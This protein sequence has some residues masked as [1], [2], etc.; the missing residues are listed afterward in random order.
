MQRARSQAS[1]AKARGLFGRR[2]GRRQAERGRARARRPR[3][4]TRT[5]PANASRQHVKPSPLSAPVPRWGTGPP[6][7]LPWGEWRE[8]KGERGGGG[9]RPKRVPSPLTQTNSRPPP[10]P[11]P[12][13]PLPKNSPCRPPSPPPPPPWPCA[14]PPPSRPPCGCGRPRTVRVR[15]GRAG[16]VW[17]VFGHQNS[18]DHSWPA[19]PPPAIPARAAPAPPTPT[20]PRPMGAAACI[21]PTQGRGGRVGAPH[22]PRA[23]ARLSRRI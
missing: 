1:G 15:G 19:L 16:K 8:E 18:H 5:A 20:A 22:R 10:P 13:S 17:V 11:P 14:R 9:V 3:G 6:L 21:P 12:T 7:P 23:G 4:G 2:L